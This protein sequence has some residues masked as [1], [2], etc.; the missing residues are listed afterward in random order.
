MAIASG[1]RHSLAKVRESTQ[2]TTPSTP[3]FKPIRNTGTTL[4]LEKTT[5]TSAEIV[6]HR[7][8]TDVRHGNYQVG[9]DVPVELSYGSH[10]DLLEE[11]FGGTW[12]VKATKTAA[13]ISA[14]ASDNSYN[15]SGNGFV[16]AGF[17]VGD[18][19]VVTGFT[20]S[21][22]NNIARGVLTSVAAGKLIVGGT[23]GDVIVDD[24]A[25]E[26]VT[27]ATVSSVLKGG[28]TRRFST[29]ERKFD[30]ITQYLRYTGC[31]VNTMSLAVAPNAMA[32]A[33]FGVVGLGADPADGSIISGATYS[34]A[35]TTS[36][37]DS[38]TGTIE[39]NGSAVAVVTQIQ[40]EVANGIEALFAVGSK[41]AVGMSIGRF[42]ITGT[43]TVF[44]DS[45]TMLNKFINETESDL[46]FETSD[47]AGNLLR[48]KIPR[49]KY[50]G[51]PPD[52]GGEGPV[53]LAM[54]IQGLYDA[55]SA[56]SLSVERIPA[57]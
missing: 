50:N 10:D 55:T 8:I 37:M 14:T 23:D 3:V 51:A 39:E 36:P 30:D 57:A 53:T 32:T 27:I 40:L 12:A 5:I 47:V 45:V 15:D 34:A 25:G 19:V 20:G 1:A 9:G 21:A 33:T 26:S 4:K 13:T 48:W 17:E 16:T 2:G 18:I 56:T 46:M 49:I 43:L 42:S 7:Q 35:T 41:P 44:F 52:V 6:S 29:F 24:A 31:E 38:F 54:P 28:T 22:L 11:L